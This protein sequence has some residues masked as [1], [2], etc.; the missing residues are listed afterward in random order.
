RD[1]PHCSYGCRL[2]SGGDVRVWTGAGSLLAP[3]GLEAEEH[4]AVP[5]GAGDLSGN[6]RKGGREPAL[7][8][9]PVCPH[10]RHML[11]A[12]PLP[13]QL[14]ASDWH[15]VHPLAP[16]LCITTVQLLTQL[17]EPLKGL[18]LQPAIGQFLDA[19]GEPAFDEAAVVEW[20]R[21]AEQHLPLS[22]E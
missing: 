19:V 14:R 12:L 9:E 15:A 16:H 21:C 17:L 10:L 18:R 2:H 4:P 8:F 13:Q 20:G 3:L 5:A 22:L 11:D 7:V 6:G 1:L